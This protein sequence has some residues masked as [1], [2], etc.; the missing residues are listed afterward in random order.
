[1]PLQVAEKKSVDARE[2]E[3]SCAQTNKVY[4][5]D[6]TAIPRNS[7]LNFKKVP[8]KAVPA[9]AQ[10]GRSMNRAPAKV[11]APAAPA[12]PLSQQA[13]AGSGVGTFD[14]PSAAGGLA[15]PEAP[16]S[17]RVPS[18]APVSLGGQAPA[19]A[20]AQPGMGG[21][22]ED[23]KIA[24]LH[25]LPTA[26]PAEQQQRGGP[27]FSNIPPGGGAPYPGY[28]CKRCNQ[29][30]HYIKYCPTNGDSAFDRRP[31]PHGIPLSTLRDADMND[32]E[33]AKRAMRAAD[34]TFKV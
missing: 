8:I 9:G 15:Y 19:L 13:A 21:E 1:M 17:F 23:D 31:V 30:G 4:A 18:S 5:D 20:P 34:G 28:I 32:P 26:A 6:R 27:A 2:I 3:L 12:V 11:A 16:P 22:S 25:A 7:I 24:N 33:D 14:A 10:G 29:G